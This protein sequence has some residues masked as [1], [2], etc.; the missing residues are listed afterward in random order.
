VESKDLLSKFKVSVVQCGDKH[1]VL[2]VKN[3]AI[4]VT[5]ELGIGPSIRLSRIPQP[6]HK[7]TEDMRFGVLI[8]AQVK[9]PIQ[10]EELLDFLGVRH[11]MGELI[12]TRQLFSRQCLRR[13]TQQERLD[14]L[15]GLI[16]LRAF[17]KGQTGYP[18]SGVGHQPDKTV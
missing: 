1:V 4:A 3:T 5:Y 11:L 9:K 15:S 14:A 8:G 7:S 6:G 12:E 18:R 10:F 13:E 2:I 16:N 17:C